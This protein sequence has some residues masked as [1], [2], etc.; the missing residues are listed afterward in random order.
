MMFLCTSFFLNFQA[1]YAAGLMVKSHFVRRAQ[2]ATT[3]D[4]DLKG[5]RQTVQGTC[6]LTSS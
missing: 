3:H 5:K 4:G 1:N 2:L 6:A